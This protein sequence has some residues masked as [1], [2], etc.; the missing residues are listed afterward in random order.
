M[1]VQ[2]SSS[3]RIRA[4][5]GSTVIAEDLLLNPGHSSVKKPLSAVTL[6]PAIADQLRNLTCGDYAAQFSQVDALLAERDKLFNNS[7][8]VD[9]SREREIISHAE[10]LSKKQ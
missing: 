8:T 3:H 4:L 10:D 1:I 7:S 5:I 2:T 9:L 6:K